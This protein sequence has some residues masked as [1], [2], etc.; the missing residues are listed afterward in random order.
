[1][2]RAKQI[3][4]LLE[5]LAVPPDKHDECRRHVESMLDAVG[6]ADQKGWAPLI[7]TAPNTI[8]PAC[9]G[10]GELLYLL[11]NLGKYAGQLPP[12]FKMKLQRLIL[13]ALREQGWDRRQIELMRW[14]FVREGRDRRK[15]GWDESYEY[16][17]AVLAGSPAEAG[18]EMMKKSYDKVQRSLPPTQRRP[19]TYRPHPHKENEA[20]ESTQNQ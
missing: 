2:T 12:E 8:E 18:P 16:A 3:A 11:K 10:S 5:L 9:L 19:R 13:W 17:S 20:P 14:S 4:Q 1:M 6:A 15:M 7:L